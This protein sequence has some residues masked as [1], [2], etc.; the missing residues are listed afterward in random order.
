MIRIELEQESDT[1]VE[2]KPMKAPRKVALNFSSLK[3]D[4]GM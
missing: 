4:F 1:T 2:Q 3:V